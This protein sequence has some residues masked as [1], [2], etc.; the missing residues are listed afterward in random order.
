ME[1]GLDEVWVHDFGLAFDQTL[2]DVKCG[3]VFDLIAWIAEGL[4]DPE[5]KVGVHFQVVLLQ[6]VD[7]GCQRRSSHDQNRILKKK[8]RFLNSYNISR[9]FTFRQAVIWGSNGSTREA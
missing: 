6:Q 7:Q 1:E 9:I 2:L 8:I 3:E 4:Q 5:E